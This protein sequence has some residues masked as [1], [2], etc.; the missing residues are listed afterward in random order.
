MLLFEKIKLVHM[1]DFPLL[2]ITGITMYV[3]LPVLNILGTK[4]NEN[5]SK[6]QNVRRSTAKFGGS[7]I[8]KLVAAAAETALKDIKRGGSAAKGS[9]RISAS[10][11]SEGDSDLELLLC[12]MIETSPALSIAKVLVPSSH[13]AFSY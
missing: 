9:N 6:M 13:R 11:P 1:F 2:F 3:F 5:R 8:E 10:Q 12:N 4:H 7:R